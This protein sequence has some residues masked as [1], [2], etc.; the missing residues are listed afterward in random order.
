MLCDRTESALD[1]GSLAAFGSGEIL[2]RDKTQRDTRTSS[3][4]LFPAG[5]TRHLLAV[6]VRLPSM[7]R[8]AGATAQQVASKQRRAKVPWDL[9]QAAMPPCVPSID[10]GAAILCLSVYDVQ[11]ETMERHAVDS[12]VIVAVGY[13]GGSSILE[14]VFRTGRTYRYFRVPPSE[15]KALR[16]AKSIGAYFNRKIRPRFRGVEVV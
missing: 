6:R 9:H 16:Q 8:R 4:A 11:K 12:S 10:D 1:A 3:M 5:L 14:V 13:D 7:L 2:G 15:Y